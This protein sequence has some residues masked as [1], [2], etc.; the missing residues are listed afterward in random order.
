MRAQ[1]VIKT[2]NVF[3][4][5]IFCLSSGRVAPKMYQLRFQ[6]TEEILRNSVIVW[7]APAGHALADAKSVQ[8]VFVVMGGVLHTPVAV[9]N[10]AWQGPLPMN[11]HVQGVQ[12]EL[13]VN[14][15]RE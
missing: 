13:G 14:A 9:E 3:K 6:A 11:S 4:D 7:V 12:S 5:I 1:R 8:T 15:L 10:Q 2:F